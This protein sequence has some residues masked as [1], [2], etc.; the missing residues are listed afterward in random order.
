M[1]DFKATDDDLDLFGHLLRDTKRFEYRPR[2]VQDRIVRLPDYYTRLRNLPNTFT[3]VQRKFALQYWQGRCA[4]CGKESQCF[5]HW[6]PISNI[7]CPGTVADNLIPLCLQCNSIKG[8]RGEEWLIAEYGSSL[9]E[10]I[11][12]YFGLLHDYFDLEV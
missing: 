12:S 7:A 4:I 3:E 11:H 1:T 2:L 6:I 5:D 10:A 9:V 8:S